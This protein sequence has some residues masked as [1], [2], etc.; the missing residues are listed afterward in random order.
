MEQW[1]DV[2]G[3][4]FAVS[5]LGRVKRTVAVPR[6]RGRAGYILKPSMGTRGYLTLCL[7]DRDRK[8]T[9]L[10]HRLVA[11]AFLGERPSGMVTNHKNAKRTD[12]RAANLEYVTQKG[13]VRHSMALGLK[14][15]RGKHGMAKLT[16]AKVAEIRRRY[17][18]G[19]RQVD[20]ASAFGVCQVNISAIVRG[21]IWRQNNETQA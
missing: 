10:V 2:T 8:W 13:N 9:V 17:K 7:T 6:H 12:N 16:E 4:P 1:R 21:K 3:W 20:L 18:A 19:A 11:N 14:P 15:V 5:D